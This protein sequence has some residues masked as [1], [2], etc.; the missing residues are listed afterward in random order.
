MKP[1]TTSLNPIWLRTPPSKAKILSDLIIQAN[2]LDN[3]GLEQKVLA[4]S[5]T[6]RW[7]GYNSSILEDTSIHMHVFEPDGNHIY[8]K[9]TLGFG[10]LNLDNADNGGPVHY[11]Q[12]CEDVVAGEYLIGLNYFEKPGDGECDDACFDPDIHWVDT[13]LSIT[14]QTPLETQT[15]IDERKLVERIGLSGEEDP[16]LVYKVILTE[17]PELGYAYSVEAIETSF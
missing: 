14:M 6:L 2:E 9:N 10:Q 11:Q 12:Y 5:S 15:F 3:Y 17:L 16:I 4:W 8:P 1:A 7:S 13:N